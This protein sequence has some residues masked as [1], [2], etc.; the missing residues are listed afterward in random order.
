MTVE[1]GD[2]DDDHDGREASE[3]PPHR[4]WLPPD[5]RLWRHPS[6]LRSAG[7]PLARDPGV[8]TQ[9]RRL[10]GGR[11]LAKVALGGAV[12]ALIA[13]GIVTSE[14]W[15]G[16]ARTSDHGGSAGQD[17]A[18][19]TTASAVL[20]A[21]GT[22]AGQNH[23]L[24]NASPTLMGVVAK[25]LPS[26][27]TVDVATGHGHVRES[28]LVFGDKGIVVTVARLL[29]GAVGISVITSDGRQV[30]ASV[31]GEDPDEG[32]AVLRVGDQLP[33]VSP[34]SSSLATTGELAIAVSMSG[35]RGS[36]PAVTIC[37]IRGVNQQV[38]VNGRPPLL[39]AIETDAPVGPAPGGVL[40]DQSGSV[41]GMTTDTTGEGGDAHWLAVPTALVHDA[42]GQLVTQGKVT[43][44]W[45]GIS[46]EDGQAAG[47]TGGNGPRGVQVLTVQSNSPAASAGLLPRDIIDAVDG[48]PVPSILDLQ[49]LLRM[50][51]PGAPVVLD[52]IRNGGHWPMHATLGSEAA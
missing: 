7:G 8:E 48:Q 25:V 52:V 47:G 18:Q 31:L 26:V 3:D 50:R 45:L 27:V 46:A 22:G 20:P 16:P 37:T 43:R 40:L 29:E 24:I 21:P 41:V 34:A 23:T 17:S 19:V 35:A 49:G 1:S 14:T 2:F 5:D 12:G 51:H 28:G 13:T 44:A 11:F 15:L 6:E 38:R 10:P 33:T 4:P 36:P 42:V 32:V 30:A 9:G 39:D